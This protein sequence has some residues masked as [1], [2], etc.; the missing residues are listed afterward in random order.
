LPLLSANLLSTPEW[1]VCAS[2]SVKAAQRRARRSDLARRAP[3]IVAVVLVLLGVIAVAVRLD[4]PSD[5]TAVSFYRTDGVVVGVPSPVD[6]PGLQTGDVVIEIAGHRLGD[7]WAA[8]PARSWGRR[9]RTTSGV[10]GLHR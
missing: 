7:G 8:L 5:G 3:A 9:S 4:A 2:A 10:R 1:A 6:S